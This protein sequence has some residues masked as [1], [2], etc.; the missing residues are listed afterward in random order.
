MAVMKSLGS[1]GESRAGVSLGVGGYDPMVDGVAVGVGREG[2]AV[3]GAMGSVRESRL[4]VRDEVEADRVDRVSTDAS[5]PA[6]DAGGGGGIMVLKRS[7]ASM[8]SS[9]PPAEPT[10]L[11][12]GGAGRGSCC[13][14]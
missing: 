12:G 3:G 2:W 9:S 8:L 6:T 5:E 14:C 11:R 13:G 4:L 1:T 7:T 10:R